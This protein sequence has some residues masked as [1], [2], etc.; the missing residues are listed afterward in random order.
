MKIESIKTSKTEKR[1]VFDY[2]KHGRLLE[3]TDE[4]NLDGVY[5]RIIKYTNDKSTYERFYL[6]T[7]GTT[8]FN[9]NGMYNL[10]N[11][12]KELNKYNTT[13][14][15]HKWYFVEVKED[16]FNFY[17]KFLETGNP[18]WLTRAERVR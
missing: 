18:A 13:K 2:G 17:F 10:T 16:A 3:R 9:P 8:F 12:D 15:K 4:D 6:R 7:D 14:G 1:Q 11:A 5:G